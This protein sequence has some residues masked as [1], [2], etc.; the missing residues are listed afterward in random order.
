[1]ATGSACGWKCSWVN[2]GAQVIELEGVGIEPAP[3]CFMAPM[4][5]SIYD[6]MHGTAEY[7][8]PA[9]KKKLIAT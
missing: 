2:N 3:S 1:M 4:V 8:Y 7:S 9:G 6:D 5:W